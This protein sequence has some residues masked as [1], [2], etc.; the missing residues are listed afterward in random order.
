[1][2]LGLSDLNCTSG[3]SSPLDLGLRDTI[4]GLGLLPSGPVLGLL[5]E[6]LFPS[7]PLFGFLGTTGL[8]L[9]LPGL[10]E[11]LE[12]LPLLG[13]LNGIL[14]TSDIPPFLGPF[15]TN[16]L[17]PKAS[18]RLV[19]VDIWFLCCLGLLGTSTTTIL[20]DLPLRLLRPS[21]FSPFSGSCDL[22]LYEFSLLFVI[23]YLYDPAPLCILRIMAG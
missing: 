23:V 5:D 2:V 14:V 11:E 7:G 18:V 9:F 16:F 4:L 3:I 1:M 13:P 10:L 22:N 15:D 21:I 17:L 12:L 20:L 6:L 8:T 19:T